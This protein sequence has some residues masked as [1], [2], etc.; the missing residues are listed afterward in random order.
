M[1]RSRRNA[2]GP[3]TGTLSG[4]VLPPL[5]GRWMEDLL[6]GAI[7][8]ETDATCRQCPMCV[9]PEES[10]IRGGQVFDPRLQCC[11]YFPT[12]PNFLVGRIL[13]DPR[14]GKSR[15]HAMICERERAPGLVTPLGIFA[16]QRYWLLYYNNP[17]GFGRDYRGRCPYHEDGAGGQSAFCGIWRHR[18]SMCAT[19]FCKF[20]RGRVGK[21]FWTALFRLLNE[22]EHTL[23]WWCVLQS[24]FGKETLERLAEFDARHSGK[25]EAHY[26]G[27]LDVEISAEQY[28]LLWGKWAERAPAFFKRASRLVDGLAAHDILEIGGPLL[29][30]R[31]RMARTAYADLLSNEIP[32]R[33]RA[34]HFEIIHAGPEASVVVSYSASDPISLPNEILRILHHFDGR[35]TSLA[36]SRIAAEERI[37]MNPGLVRR[38]LDY[39]LLEPCP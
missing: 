22:I 23:Q 25:M 5:Y 28:R 32:P 29:E 34:S 19:S 20:V 8:P 1:G 37:T 24:D 15:V 11:T 35:P 9:P 18:Q 27:R 36:L 2:A 13:N 38:L 30:V 26:H 12:L 4:N 10:G 16:P 31:A 21:T 17:E 39:A 6:G 33:V 3:G 7:P 14:L